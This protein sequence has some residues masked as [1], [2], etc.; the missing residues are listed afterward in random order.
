MNKTL[1]LLI[2]S[3]LFENIIL[4]PSPMAK[5]IVN[6]LKIYKEKKIR[7]LQN[8]DESSSSDTET[9][10]DLE[11][12]KADPEAGPYELS[13]GAST[14]PSNYNSKKAFNPY[15]IDSNIKESIIAKIRIAKQRTG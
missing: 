5:R 14:S 10:K 2:F 11:T 6:V 15:Q 8:S 7:E 9:G 3:V 12:N 13:S 4:G 1:F